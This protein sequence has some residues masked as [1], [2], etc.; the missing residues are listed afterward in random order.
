MKFGRRKLLTTTLGAGQAAL[1]AR[2]GLW[3]RPAKAGG[4]S[5][6]PTK[7]LTVYMPGGLSHE[8]M[9]APFINSEVPMY[10]PR[11][12]EGGYD[13]EHYTNFD[14][15]G[16]ADADAP[17]RRLRGP[18]EW[19]WGNDWAD[20]PNGEALGYAWAAP[21]YR[22]YDRTAVIHGVDQGTAA[23]PSGTVAGM[24]GVAGGNFAAP[25]IPAVIA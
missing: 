6:M 22:L 23:H 10:V 12:D 16:D 2:Y 4:A 17:I 25:A 20:V 14:A 24:C 7:I 18:I 9:W 8:L 5:S 21:E 13:S 15:S 19:N 1:L 3:S 11:Y